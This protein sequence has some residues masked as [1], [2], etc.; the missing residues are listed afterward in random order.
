MV[1]RSKRLK[2]SFACLPYEQRL[3]TVSNIGNLDI[4]ETQIRFGSATGAQENIQTP[5]N[6]TTVR[7]VTMM[8][9]SFSAEFCLDAY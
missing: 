9:N 3:E 7:T 5:P 2:F 6:P 8:T 1:V 4:A